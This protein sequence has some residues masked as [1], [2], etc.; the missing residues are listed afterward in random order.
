MSKNGYA[1]TLPHSDGARPVTYVPVEK[2]NESIGAIVENMNLQQ[3]TIAD[4]VAKFNELAIKNQ[5]LAQKVADLERELR[6]D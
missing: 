1:A 4:L 3:R 2:F 5:G 6:P